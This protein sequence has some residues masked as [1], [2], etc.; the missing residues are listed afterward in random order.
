M[1]KFLEFED[2]EEAAASYP[3]TFFIPGMTERQSQKVG[4]SVRLHFLLQDVGP[5]EPRAERIWVTITQVEG[6]RGTYKG[7]LKTA[8]V[9]FRELKIDDEVAFE[10]R[11]IARTIIKK[12]DPRWIDSS[13]LRALVSNMC[14]EKGN[15]VRFLYREEPDRSEDSGW[16]MFSGNEPE[17]YCDN[18]SN[19][20]LMNVA[21]MLDR[22]PTLLEP[23][24]AGAGAVFEREKL[25]DAWQKVTD[26][27]PAGD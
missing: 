15:G 1:A 21:Y 23:L 8:P 4:D 9:F 27:E 5:D 20:R 16:R 25:G 24:K 26:W 17:G 12:G 7:T 6:A 11:H 2:V 18:A 3:E 22:D 13:E 14:L 19:I 10:P